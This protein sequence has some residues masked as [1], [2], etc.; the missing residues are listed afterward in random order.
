MRQTTASYKSTSPN[1]GQIQVSSCHVAA[2]IAEMHEAVHM[3]LLASASHLEKMLLVA[4]VL[5]MRANGGKEVVMQVLLSSTCWPEAN[6]CEI[7][8]FNVSFVLRTSSLV[9]Q[10]TEARD[11]WIGMYIIVS[12]RITYYQLVSAHGRIGLL[13]S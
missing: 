9:C 3:Q 8:C 5:E 11:G 2:A 7:G 4:M 6:L 12:Q 13:S 1:D 10:E